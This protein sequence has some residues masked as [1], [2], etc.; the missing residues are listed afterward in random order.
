MRRSHAQ[1]ML[2]GT[3]YA[4][5]TSIQDHVKLLRTRKAA[6]DNLSMA[7]MSD[8]TWRGILI[9]SKPPTAGWLPVIPSLYT[10]TSSAD[11]VSSMLAHGMILN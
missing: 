1:E 10:H 8:E 3:M 11:I 4:E 5:G 7:V 9:R 6:I 2:N